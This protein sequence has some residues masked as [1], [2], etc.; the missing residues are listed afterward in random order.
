MVRIRDLQD[1][2]F[3]AYGNIYEVQNGPETWLCS[4]WRTVRVYDKMRIRDLLGFTDL[5]R[6][7]VRH[8]ALKRTRRRHVGVLS[9]RQTEPR[10]NS[11]G[12]D[13]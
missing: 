7:C 11:T 8:A 12:F 5:R 10:Q 13:L 4:R 3:T 2:P 1:L 9:V 6:V